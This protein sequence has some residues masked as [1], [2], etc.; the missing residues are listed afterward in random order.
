LAVGYF[1]GA[2]MYIV[3]LRK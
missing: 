2:T 1:L 3:E